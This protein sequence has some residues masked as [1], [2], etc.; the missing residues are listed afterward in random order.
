MKDGRRLHHTALWSSGQQE[1]LPLVLHMRRWA[2]GDLPTSN[3]ISFYIEEPEAHYSVAKNYDGIDCPG[4]QF[5]AKGR[6][7]I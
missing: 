1:S 4:V 2:E 7:N 3:R 5:R 6:A